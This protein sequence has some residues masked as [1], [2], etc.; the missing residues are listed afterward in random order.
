LEGARAIAKIDL[1]KRNNIHAPKHY[2][3]WY[4]KWKADDIE[5]E[6][7]LWTDQKAI[8]KVIECLQGKYSTNPRL[9]AEKLIF[10][11]C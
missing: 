6:E 3:Q 7:N 8:A 5:I 2:R 1:E 9:A 4:A 10:E 11:V